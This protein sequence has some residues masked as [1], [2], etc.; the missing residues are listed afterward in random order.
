MGLQVVR[1]RDAGRT[2][3][4]VERVGLVDGVEYGYVFEAITEG[5]TTW[6]LAMTFTNLA[7]GQAVYPPRP[8]AG[9]VDVIRSDDNGADLAFRAQLDEGVR[10][11][12]D[13]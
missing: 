5:N 12:P 10:R 1:S 9:S 7:G 3:G 8:A 2:F 11:H 13:Q 4:P 6:M